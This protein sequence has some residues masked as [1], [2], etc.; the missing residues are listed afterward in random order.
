MKLF[1]ANYGR[2]GTIRVEWRKCSVCS[3]DAVC[4]AIDPSEGEYNVGAVCQPCTVQVFAAGA[5]APLGNER[6]TLEKTS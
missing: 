2:T 3:R 5:D 4:L 6:P 1:D